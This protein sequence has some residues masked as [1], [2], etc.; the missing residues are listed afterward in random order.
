MSADMDETEPQ[1]L[2]AAEAAALGVAAAEREEAFA[3]GSGAPRRCK[4]DE[5]LAE[6]GPS[7]SK[8]RAPVTMPDGT[9]RFDVDPAL[10]D[11]ELDV[12]RGSHDFVDTRERCNVETMRSMFSF[13]PPAACADALAQSCLERTLA[14]DG[15]SW[16]TL[17]DRDR[18]FL[19]EAKATFVQEQLARGLG[20]GFGRGN[21]CRLG[22]DGRTVTPR[23][24]EAAHLVASPGNHFPGPRYYAGEP[25]PARGFAL[26]PDAPG[27]PLC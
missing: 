22:A 20:R 2:S 23:E 5:K 7:A 15:L 16:S 17:S 11:R 21:D 8:R 25:D 6:G 3:D 13:L 18:A 27:G 1:A 10:W 24:M 14:K 26:S 9:V 19:L 4:G 12:N